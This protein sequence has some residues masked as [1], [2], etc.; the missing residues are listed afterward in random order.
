M[1][2][3]NAIRNKIFEEILLTEIVVIQRCDRAEKK[4]I[5][6]QKK[7]G[8]RNQKVSQVNRWS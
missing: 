2:I 3:H 6:R 1:L 7:K 4:G 8:G 5:K